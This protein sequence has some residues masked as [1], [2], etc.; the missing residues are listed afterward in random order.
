MPIAEM[1]GREPDWANA[2]AV[3][4]GDFAKTNYGVL[5]L[6]QS[7]DRPGNNNPTCPTC[8]RE[9]LC[10]FFRSTT[11]FDRFPICFKRRARGIFP[12]ASAHITCTRS[13][14]SLL[15][16]RKDADTFWSIAKYVF[17]NFRQRTA[18]IQGMLSPGPENVSEQMVKWAATIM[19]ESIILVE[20]TVQKTSE[21]IKGTSVS[22]A[23]VVIKKVGF[24]RNSSV[25]LRFDLPFT[26]LCRIECAWCTA[27][28]P[29][30]R[31]KSRGR[32]GEGRSPVQQGAA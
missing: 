17:I 13:D 27:I 8:L 23:Q 25:L 1:V 15:L 11:H 2:M 7:Q 9:A 30:G 31:I 18:S 4:E 29:G 20:G 16:Y 26:A 28:F 6:N 12:R 3:T 32:P 24:S 14:L 5:P 22:D 19:P 10:V 21:E